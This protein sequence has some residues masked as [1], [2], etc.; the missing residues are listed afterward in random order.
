MMCFFMVLKIDKNIL[1]LGHPDFN[2][3]ATYVAQA[4]RSS[5]NCSGSSLKDIL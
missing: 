4:Y 5:F 3:S 2:A 1:K